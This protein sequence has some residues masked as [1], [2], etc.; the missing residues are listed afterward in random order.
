MKR[1]TQLF[2]L[3]LLV[4]SC[5][6]YQSASE[7]DLTDVPEDDIVRIANDDIEY[8]IIIIEP[9]FNTWLA[10]MAKPEGYYSQSYMEARNSV[11]VIEWNNRVMQPQ[12]YDPNLY[13]LRI[14]YN[15][16]IDY[17]YDVNYKLFN[18]F[19][20]FQLTY[21]QRLSSFVPRI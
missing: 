4:V 20:Y 11:N 21:K 10:S 16:N 9:G 12:T 3:A 2:I 14:D 17:G 13:E 19:N 18:Y 7:V 6:S 5:G 1:I 15:P 8:E